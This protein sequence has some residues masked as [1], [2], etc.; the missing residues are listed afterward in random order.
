MFFLD[1]YKQIFKIGM[2]LDRIIQIDQ[3]DDMQIRACFQIMVFYVTHDLLIGLF[4][5]RFMMVV[6]TADH[7]TAGQRDGPHMIRR[8]DR[9]ADHMIVYVILMHQIVISHGHARGENRKVIF[10]GCGG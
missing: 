8:Q 9:E 1:T 6:I 5:I 7:S 3:T 4:N 10:F 2:F